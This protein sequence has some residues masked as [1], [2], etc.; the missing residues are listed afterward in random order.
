MIVLRTRK[1]AQFGEAVFDALRVEFRIGH[2]FTAG[3]ERDRRLKAI[4]LH[5]VAQSHPVGQAQ[6]PHHAFEFRAGRIDRHWRAGYVGDHGREWRCHAVGEAEARVK[7]RAQRH[8]QR[9][10]DFAHLGHVARAD[11]VGHRLG[12]DGLRM[13]I[14]QPFGWAC[15]MR[16]ERS[17][18][19]RY[20]IAHVA[21]FIGRAHRD[22]RHRGQRLVGQIVVREQVL[23]HGPANNGKEHVVYLCAGGERADR[24]DIG[25]RHA[26]P[27]DNAV[28]RK[29]HIE[30]RARGEHFAMDLE[31]AS[32]QA[33]GGARQPGQRARGN[34]ELPRRVGDS[35]EPASRQQSGG[36][37]H[38][39]ALPFVGL[40]RRG[41]V[42]IERVESLHQVDPAHPVNRGMV[43]FGDG[44]KAARRDPGH[45]VEPFD[46]REFPRRAR[47]IEWARKDPRGL[48]AQLS[49]VT[50]F[51]QRQVADVVFEI[52]RLVLDPI[53]IIEIE[54]HPHQ[55]LAHGLG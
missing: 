2:D 18:H 3:G 11:R 22:R 38:V 16:A 13:D 15:D 31:V 45:V 40:L 20:L 28:G 8:K 55:P 4:A 25:Q 34:F 12:V 48:N 42:R 1:I 30:A 39:L 29:R 51:G 7:L 17:D 23:A 19:R 33:L 6:Q 24:L 27:F 9:G 14:G 46:D 37:G 21:L 49:P 53:R 32:Q 47:Q 50:R 10:A 26:A 52:E 43:H 41:G 36:V 54:R 5:D 35:V 44:G